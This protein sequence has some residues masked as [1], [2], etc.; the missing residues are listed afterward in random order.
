MKL[1]KVCPTNERDLKFFGELV[2]LTQ[3][4]PNSGMDD[5]SG[6]TGR[7]EVLK[8]YKT[9]A[10]KYVAEHQRVSQWSGERTVI[11]AKVCEKHDD[12]IGFFGFSDLAKEIYY[13]AEIET[14]L[15]VE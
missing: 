12:I 8:L 3:N 10:G 9:Q 5:F 1:I 13:D 7:Y 14:A 11:K 4:S 15:N 6:S 2:A